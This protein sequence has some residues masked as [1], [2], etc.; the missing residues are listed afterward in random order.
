[1]AEKTCVCG[2]EKNIPFKWWHKYKETKYILGHNPHTEEARKKVSEKLKGNK[3]R[4]GHKLTENHKKKLSVI[5][6]QAY[7][8]GIIIPPALGKNGDKAFNWKGGVTPQN[9]IIRSSEKYKKWREAIFKRDDYICQKC[10]ARNGNGKAIYL[11]AHH[12]F[13]FSKYP[14]LRF[15]IDNG[16]TLCKDCHME[17]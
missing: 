3:H 16:E 14:E 6:K 9:I 7:E 5:M 17:A 10:D 15:D 13:S 8:N 2:C 12:I 1:M 4:L 11:H